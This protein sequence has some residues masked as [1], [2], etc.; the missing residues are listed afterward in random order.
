MY[1]SKSKN[2]LKKS[3]LGAFFVVLALNGCENEQPKKKQSDNTTDLNV[4]V[5]QPV[6]RDY[7]KIKKSGVIRMITRYNSNT[8]FLQQGMERGFEYEL[9]RQFAKTHNLTVEVVIIQKNDNP[10]DMLNSGKGDVIA[11]NYTITPERE[12]YVDFT[13]PYNIV[14]QVVAFSDD[15]D[16]PPQNLEDLSDITI[17]VRRN[18][19]YYHRLMELK[20]QGYDLNVNLVSDDMDTESL[21]YEVM[22]G[23]YEATVADDN[24]F[25]AASKYMGGLMEGPKIARNDTIAWAVRKNATKLQD[26]MNQFLYKHF[27][28]GGPNEQ[29]KRSA[30]LNILMHRYF[31][32]GPQIA[33][34]Y[35]P[36]SQFTNA[37]ILSPYDHLIKSVADSAGIDWKMLTAIVAQESKFNPN[38]K[39]WAGAIGLMQILPRFTDTNDV[40]KLY[41]PKTN[42]QAG[43]KVLEEHL[44]HYSYLDTT[45]RWQFALAAYNAGQGHVADARRLAIDLN[46][47]PNNWDNVADALLKLMQRKYY[48]NARYGFCRGIE[49]VRYVR[50]IMNRYETYQTILALAEKRQGNSNNMQGVLGIKMFN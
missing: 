32:E 45:N 10:Y 33:D 3:V 22:Q 44:H 2:T 1:P 49:T 29:P 31:E 4:S 30:L 20:K 41:D 37:G 26:E 7:N 34:Y 27:R 12:K 11:A 39:S 24:I 25:K 23:K 14:D 43:V 21:L 18:S 28:P 38:S 16:N 9:L 47:N 50:E 8:Y 19:S 36:E 35:N 6:D 46:K 17:S 5:T 15:M 42:L 13:R 48:Q 40:S